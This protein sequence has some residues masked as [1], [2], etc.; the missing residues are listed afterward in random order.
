M[1]EHLFEMYKDAAGEWRFR[2]VASNGQIIAVSGEGFVSKNNC[3]DSINLVKRAASNA[4]V[5]NISEVDEPDSR[6]H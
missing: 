1:D 3:L 6:N 4:R 5:I 2:L